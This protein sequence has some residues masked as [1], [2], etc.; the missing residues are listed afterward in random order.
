MPTTY[1]E[2]RE[3]LARCPD[4]ALI[5]AWGHPLAPTTPLARALKS[6]LVARDLLP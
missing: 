4:D 3:T 1:R 6:E 2:W 5:E